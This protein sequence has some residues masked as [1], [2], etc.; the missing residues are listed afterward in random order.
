MCMLISIAFIVVCMEYAI[1][2]VTA[3]TI[4]IPLSVLRGMNS[5]LDS[6]CDC[7][8]PSAYIITEEMEVSISNDGVSTEQLIRVYCIYDIPK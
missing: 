1:N 8:L 4:V 3:D 7:W 6:K 5:T 2:L